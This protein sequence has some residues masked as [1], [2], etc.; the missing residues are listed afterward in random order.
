MTSFAPSCTYLR[1]LGYRALYLQS[2]LSKMSY[3]TPFVA[4]FG[5]SLQ[6]ICLSCVLLL[7][8]TASGLK[9][10][11]NEVEVDAFECPSGILQIEIF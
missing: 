1:S 6:E 10:C 4:L 11:C 2:G 8:S 7:L 9:N 3:L 5:S